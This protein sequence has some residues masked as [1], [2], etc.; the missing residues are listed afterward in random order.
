[1]FYNYK[2]FKIMDLVWLNFVTLVPQYDTYVCWKIE[3]M[4]ERMNACTAK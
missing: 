1:M 3:W 4:N 2:L